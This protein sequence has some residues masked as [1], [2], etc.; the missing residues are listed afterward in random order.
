[1]PSTAPRPSKAAASRLTYGAA[2]R[3]AG[4]IGFEEEKEF[5]RLP[6]TEMLTREG[7]HSR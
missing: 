5:H 3:H 1:M 6:E 4:Q 2:I 7:E